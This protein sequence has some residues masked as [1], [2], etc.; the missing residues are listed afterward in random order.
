MAISRSSTRRASSSVHSGSLK[1]LSS[2]RA[3]KFLYTS[4]LF[5]L[6]VL[7]EKISLMLKESI[8]LISLMRASL[9]LSLL[10]NLNWSSSQRF[11]M[12]SISCVQEH[13]CSTAR[14]TVI[15]IIVCIFC[16][17]QLFLYLFKFISQEVLKN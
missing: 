6:K 17:T 11:P 13:M 2:L 12:R 5:S 14:S 15:S 10:W 3:A 7:Q 8:S 1:L 9:M 16:L 4:P